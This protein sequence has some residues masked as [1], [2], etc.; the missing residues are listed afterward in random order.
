MFIFFSKINRLTFGVCKWWITLKFHDI[1]IIFYLFQWNERYKTIFY[2]YLLYILNNVIRR[3]SIYWITTA[4]IP[5]FPK[6]ILILFKFYNIYFYWYLYQNLILRC[7]TLSI[8]YIILHYQYKYG[9]EYKFLRITFH[10][11]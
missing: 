4:V 7:V 8:R 2:R 11:I 1:L 5:F 10:I 6:S 9:L 3:L